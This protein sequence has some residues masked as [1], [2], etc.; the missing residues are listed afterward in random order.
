MVDVVEFWKCIMSKKIP[1]KGTQWSIVGDSWAARHTTYYIPELG[2]FL[3]I[4]KESEQHPTHI[5]ITHAHCDHTKALASHLLEPVGTPI[6]VAPKPSANNIRQLVN[7]YHRATKHNDNAI[8][9]WRL[10]EVSIPIDKNDGVQASN[11][12]IPEPLF[13]SEI[14]KIKNINFKI[15][16]F[17]CAHSI[18]TTG[19]GFIELRSKLDDQYVGLPQEDIN[20][21]KNSGVNVT[22]I[23]EIPHFCYLGDTTYQ[24]FYIDKQCK[25]PNPHIE[26]Y[27]TIIT[28]CTFLYSTEIKQ[29]KDTKHMHWDYLRNYVISHPN[30]N[31]VLSHFS[32]RYNPKEVRDFFAINNFPNVFPLINDQEE[33][34]LNK[35]LEKLQSGELS[36]S[37]KAK[38]IESVSYCILCSSS[39]KQSTDQPIIL[40][41]SQLLIDI[42]NMVSTDD[43]SNVDNLISEN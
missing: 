28:E 24:V 32:A 31:F 39:P 5:F 35:I 33:Y 25:I 2:I 38:L 21:E 34:W 37:T 16:L 40:D 9:K 14:M 10:I 30:I 43:K 7:S 1:I 29:A 19:Y 6:V 20:K 15:E 4:G 42:P 18:P 13:M 8:V 11:I 41:K 23:V 22:K 27:G 3:D 12:N 36:D 26:K 17:K